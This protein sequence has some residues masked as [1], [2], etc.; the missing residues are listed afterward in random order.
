MTDPLSPL[1]NLNPTVLIMACALDLLIGDPYWLPHPVRMMGKTILKVETI[2]RRYAKTPFAQKFSGILLVIIIVLPVFIITAFITGTVYHLHNRPLIIMGNIILVYLV[3]TTIAVKELINEG[4]KVIKAIEKNDIDKARYKLSMI[5][6]RDTNR[7]DEKQILRADMETISENLSDGVIA[8]LFYLVLGG[9]P[10]AMVYKAINTL[11]SMVGYKNETY[12][13]LGWAS[14]RLD[15][16]ANYIP[17]RIT[18]TLIVIASGIALRSITAF[19]NALKTMIRDGRK[20]PS[21]NS[22]IPESAMAGAVGI[23]MGGPSTYAGV[24]VEKP[25][26]GKDVTDNYLG[27]ARRSVIIAEVASILG[28]G[29]AVMFL[30]IRSL[31]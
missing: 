1:F 8:P 15:D 4:K 16:L 25:I 18:G 14:A 22:G 23:T 26:I 28:M 31:I 3:S 21:P 5:V 6:G 9:I 27:A 12:L 7:L 17:A 10:L 19:R 29:M 2:L 20:H 11:D 30:K 24:L 13:Y